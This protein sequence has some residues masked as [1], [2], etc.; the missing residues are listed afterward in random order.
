MISPEQIKQKQIKEINQPEQKEEANDVKP[1]K[2]RI[3]SYYQN[4][5]K[6]SKIE[7]NSSMKNDSNNIPTT[8]NNNNNIISK[9]INDTNQ[10]KTKENRYIRNNIIPNTNET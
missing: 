4:R 1:T 10:N 7:Q 3:F 5:K 8:T 9:P 2:G 6:L